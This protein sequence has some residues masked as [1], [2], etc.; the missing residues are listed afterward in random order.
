LSR[1]GE[2]N[3]GRIPSPVRTRAVV[4]PFR[5]GGVERTERSSLTE[6]RKTK[7]ETIK[8]KKKKKREKKKKTKEEKEK[9]KKNKEKRSSMGHENLDCQTGPL[10]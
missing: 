6:Q 8:K 4:V 1:Q 7:T 10:D 3:Q 2:D 5:K 9:E